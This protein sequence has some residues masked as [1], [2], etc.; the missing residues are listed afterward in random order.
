MLSFLDVGFHHFSR[1]VAATDSMVATENSGLLQLH[2]GKVGL[3]DKMSCIQSSC[4]LK[5]WGLCLVLC[6]RN[7]L[8]PKPSNCKAIWEYEHPNPTASRL[9]KISSFK[10]DSKWKCEISKAFLHA[11]F[12]T[13]MKHDYSYKI[14]PYINH[15]FMFFLFSLWFWVI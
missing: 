13:R 7:A 1:I 3:R 4:H 10:T 6:H 15:Y 8:L 5:K 2:W 14:Y 12:V 11:V 9:S